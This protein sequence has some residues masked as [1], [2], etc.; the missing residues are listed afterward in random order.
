MARQ[1]SL[2][3]SLLLLCTSAPAFASAQDEG[4]APAPAAAEE[5]V[6]APLAELPIAPA[7]VASK[8]L[9]YDVTFRASSLVQGYN[10]L[11]L[12]PFDG[13]SDATVRDTDDKSMFGYSDAG[14]HIVARP[15]D[16]LSLTLDGE[17]ETQWPAFVLNSSP[18]AIVSLYGL[19]LGVSLFEH[20][21][22]SADLSMG[23]Q[24]FTLGGVP[25]DYI[26]SGSVDGLVAT[27]GL[28]SAGR[29]R[30]VPFD[31]FSGQE[32]PEA[33][34]TRYATGRDTTFGF[35][36]DNFTYRSGL[37]YDGAIT[38]AAQ[39]LDLGAYYF[40][41]GI[42]GSDYTGSGADISYGGQLGNFSDGDYQN[43]YGAR[44]AWKME[45]AGDGDLA[46]PGASVIGAYLE[47]AMSQGVD[48]QA[49]VA[50][51]DEVKTDG[52]AYGAGIDLALPLSAVLLEM[53]GSFYHFD[54]ADYDSNGM[55]F[56]GG[57]TGF[58][59][60]KVGG[61]AIGRLAGW[62][63]SASLATDGVDRSPQQQSRTA[64]TEFVSGTI[65]ATVGDTSVKVSGWNYRDTS[66]SFVN[67]DA[68]ELIPEPPYGYSRAEIA[69]Q[70]RLGKA[71]GTEWEAVVSHRID[72]L[73]LSA[74]GGI[75]LPDNFY[76]VEVDRIVDGD[77][78][79]LGG[80][81]P[82]TVVGVS[83]ELTF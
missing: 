20:G 29:L 65:S 57:F 15:S 72:E 8:A 31:F 37:A 30:L 83:A 33:G 2:T 34:Y 61:V 41:A 18:T 21:G 10:N 24:P 52:N 54:G 5:A 19:S 59:G 67:F 13:S 1:S 28:G 39:R 7:A 25:K 14:A 3:F 74:V 4:Q 53:G 71:L 56:G 23:R 47:G 62:R 49:L 22:V 50:A 11:D 82:M 9:H 16:R 58:R 79:A 26:M 75:F 81:E 35:D 66:H 46:T 12:R 6:A 77:D 60:S 42:G 73:K 43:L 17:V 55:E 40:F 64:G 78:T 36:G 44:A 68:L 45:L 48:R 80:S 76:D 70:K 27:I 69:A 63:P 32:L 38:S 51:Y